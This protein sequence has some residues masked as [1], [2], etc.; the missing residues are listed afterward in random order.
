MTKTHQKKITHIH[1]LAKEVSGDK[2]MKAI[3]RTMRDRDRF[4]Y[5]Y[6]RGWLDAEE[7]ERSCR[8]EK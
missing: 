2:S 5:G 7:F 8:R 6:L 4:E 1:E 3:L